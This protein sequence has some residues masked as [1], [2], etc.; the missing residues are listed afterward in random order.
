MILKAKVNK[1]FSSKENWAAIELSDLP[2][3]VTDKIKK[4][5]IVA[6][7]IINN[8]VVGTSLIMEGKFVSH[9]KYGDQF[10]VTS[11]KMD[12]TDSMSMISFLSSSFIKGCG[13]KTASSIVE[14]FGEKTNDIIQ[15]DYQRLT[16]IDKIGPKKAQQ[17]HD[18]FVSYQRYYTIMKLF[19]G[20]ITP[21]KVKAIVDVYK[22][23]S[24]KVIK[25]DPYRLICDIRGFGFLTVD[26]LALSSGIPLNSPDRVKAAIVY[27]LD[28][29]ADKFGHCY[30]HVDELGDTVKDLLKNTEIKDD[31]IAEQIK[32]LYTENYVYCKADKTSIRVYLKDLHNAEVTLASKI[33]DLKN[34]YTKTGY[35]NMIVEENLNLVEIEKNIILEPLQRE[36]VHRSLKNHISIITGGPGTGKSTIVYAITQAAKVLGKEIVLLAP[37]GRAARRLHE[38][39]KIEATTICLFNYRWAYKREHDYVFIIDE[40]SMID[41]ETANTLFKKIPPDSIVILVG[42]TDQLP[43]IGSGNFFK[44]LVKSR[45]I[46]YTRLNISHRF[47]GMIAQN[48]ATINRGKTNLRQGDDFKIINSSDKE[49]RQNLILKNYYQALRENGNDF[50]K[51]QIIVPMRQRGETASNVLNEII[52]EKINPIKAG[53]K[54]FG[55]KKLRI[56]DRVMQ[57]KNNYSLDVSNGDCG[58][59][60]GFDDDKIIVNM[61]V[62]GIKVYDKD[63]AED[64][65]IAYAITVHKSQGSEYD[66][67]ICSYGTSDFV[68]LKKKLIYTAITRARKKMI[69]IHEPKALHLAV[70]NIYEE[71]RNTSLVEMIEYF[72]GLKF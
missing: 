33:S 22:D 63:S 3:E 28:Q 64:L 5:N 54:T 71:I 62:G 40:S 56:N 17:I 6:A 8:P 29:M 19:N 26:K 25:E 61:D 45:I 11:S 1:V 34:N 49:E 48:A 60:E 12:E 14:K 46:P 35:K 44:D 36:A 24:E 69:L 55:P 30:V 50:K 32:V 23:D 13:E 43:P 37:T 52:R 53:Q 67:V 31:V 15:N 66:T 27:T 7:G 72:D 68:M 70:N 39:T 57:V 21:K 20:A 59:V 65:V 10:K 58:V 47:S 51:V 38:A 4:Q 41:I 9:K 16:E 2:I 42:D 18:S